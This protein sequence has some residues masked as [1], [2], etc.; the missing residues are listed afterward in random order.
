MSIRPSESPNYRM[1]HVQN[2]CCHFE[3]NV[4]LAAQYPTR[5]E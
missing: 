3:T 1:S 5:K 2:G 4:V